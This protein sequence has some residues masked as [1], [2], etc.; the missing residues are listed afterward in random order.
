MI[1]WRQWLE[2]R[3]NHR[4]PVDRFFHQACTEIALQW[5]VPE[6]PAPAIRDAPV[7]ELGPGPEND[8][9]D[10]LTRDGVTVVQADVACLTGVEDISYPWET[11]GRLPWP[12]NHFAAVIAREVL[13]HVPDIF[14]MTREIHRVLMAHGRF[15]FSTPFIFPLHDY[16]DGDYW[17]L[18][19]KAWLWL[20]ADSGFSRPRSSAE[21]VREL[22][23]SWQYPVT[24][25]V[26]G[27]K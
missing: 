18:S 2:N 16:D 23:G 7:L 3:E 14:Q 12:D 5:E 9:R 11:E 13:E 6:G 19:P 26:W 4:L 10:L 21:A 17:R 20:L 1:N 22:W 8:L 25:L 15:Y 24:V 27:T